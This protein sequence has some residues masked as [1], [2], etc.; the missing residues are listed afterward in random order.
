[1]QNPSTI[2]DF[3]SDQP[4]RFRL[5]DQIAPGTYLALVNASIAEYGAMF[6]GTSPGQY[7]ICDPN[8]MQMGTNEPYAGQRFCSDAARTPLP[9]DS[10][11]QPYCPYPSNDGFTTEQFSVYGV[12]AATKLGADPSLVQSWSA[13]NDKMWA[14]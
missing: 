11:G 12:I 9:N 10:N 5:L 1:M 14:P 13:W 4:T 3:Q 8:N 7:R 2:L 6:F